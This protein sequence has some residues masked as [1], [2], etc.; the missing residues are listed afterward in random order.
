MVLLLWIT[1]PA[2]F[3][4]CTAIFLLAVHNVDLPTM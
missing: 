1:L 4:G 2:I 3:L